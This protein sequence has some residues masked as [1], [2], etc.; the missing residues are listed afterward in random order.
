M[1]NDDVR[2]I[3]RVCSA[4]DFLALLS[5]LHEA[6]TDLVLSALM[7]AKPAMTCAIVNELSTTGMTKDP[8]KEACLGII[9]MEP[10]N[11]NSYGAM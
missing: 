10:T 6:M 7:M 1:M 5:T 11:R 3:F 2:E 4:A 9:R 8:C